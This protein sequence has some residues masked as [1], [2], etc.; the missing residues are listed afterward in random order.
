MK[1]LAIIEASSVTGPAKN[2]L[3]FCES[4]RQHRFA[5]LPLIETSITTFLRNSP[6]QIQN[7]FI[8]RAIEN[9]IAINGI[10]ERFRFDTRVIDE[11]KKVV[12]RLQP[13]IIQTHNVK[14]HFLMNASGLWRAFP[15]VAFHHGYTTTDFKMRV[16]N[17][18]DRWSLRNAHRV[19][20]VSQ[21]FARQLERR[22]AQTRGLRILHNAVNVESFLNVNHEEAE[23][24]KLGFGIAAHEPVMVAIGR[25]SKEKGQD[26]LL[27]ACARLFQASRECQAKLLIVG[28]GVERKNLEQLTTTLGIQERVV[29]AGQVSNV[30]PFYAIADLMVLPSHSEGSPNVLLEAMAARVPVISTHVGGVPEIATHQETAWLVNARDPK[31]MAEAMHALLSRSQLGQKLAAKAHAHVIQHHSPQSR[32]RTLLEFYQE[33][34]PKQVGMPAETA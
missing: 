7:E 30:K 21:A 24:L 27:Q 8:T 20:T 1:I 11:L 14:S 5:D 15:W 2:L 19:V 26:D 12:E 16:Y 9:G 6:D 29:F 34:V 33:L 3:A 31:A 23:R 4:A 13:D 17:Q 18:F 28:D 10:T 25:L 22:G 32:L